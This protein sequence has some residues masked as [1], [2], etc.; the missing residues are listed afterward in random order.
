MLFVEVTLHKLHS[1]QNIFTKEDSNTRTPFGPTV[2]NE[3]GSTKLINLTNLLQ[4][5][6]LQNLPY[7]K[8]LTNG[9]IKQNSPN[10]ISMITTGLWIS[11]YLK[12][13][14]LVGYIKMNVLNINRIVR[15][16]DFW[17]MI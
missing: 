8:L 14:S 13:F 6:R 9:R 7:N 5:N 2:P 1:T 4:A 16:L 10:L 3:C 11:F 15:H 17:I 12:I